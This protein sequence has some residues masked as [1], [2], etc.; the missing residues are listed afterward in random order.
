M[1]LL[2]NALYFPVLGFR[3][4]DGQDVNVTCNYSTPYPIPESTEYYLYSG[5]DLTANTYFSLTDAS[6]ILLNVQITRTTVHSS[7]SLFRGF[8]GTGTTPSCRNQW[9]NRCTHTFDQD[10]SCDPCEYSVMVF[11][12]NNLTYDAEYLSDVTTTTGAGPCILSVTGTSFTFMSSPV[13][14]PKVFE[15]AQ[16]VRSPKCPKPKVSSAQ[17]FLS[18]KYPTVQCSWK[19]WAADTFLLTVL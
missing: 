2:N 10:D 14:R 3:I 4:I 19:F 12:Y 9:L 1:F 17:S 8:F 16:R 13:F 15:R 5:I 7:T 11:N 6:V 18:P